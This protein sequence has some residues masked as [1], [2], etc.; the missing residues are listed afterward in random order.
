MYFKRRYRFF[1][2]LVKCSVLEKNLIR[3][4]FLLVVFNLGFG[5]AFYFLEKEAQSDLTWLD[6]LW[7]S[8]VTMTTVGYGDLYPHSDAARFLVAYPCF[9]FGIALL[10]YFL[11]ITT[12]TFIERATRKKRGLMQINLQ[13]HI[14]LCNFPGIERIQ[15]VISE[16]SAHPEYS[17]K[18][19]VLVSDQFTELPDSLKRQGL[20]FV[21][22]DPNQE[23]VLARASISTSYG[24]IVFAEDSNNQYCDSQTFVIGSTLEIIR[25]E[26][27]RP[28]KI[29]LEQV[30]LE[31][32]KMLK[33][34]GSDGVVIRGA[35]SDFLLVQ[36]FLYPGTYFVYKQL[37]SNLVGSQIYLLETR[38]INVKVYQFQRAMLES[39]YK[40][41]LLGIVENG[42]CL[43]NPEKD[44]V[45]TCQARLI[46]LAESAA[47]FQKIEK[48][49][50]KEIKKKAKN[51]FH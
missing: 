35:I 26:K 40:I 51:L 7:W 18:E 49:I 1:V 30:S 9:I 5:S 6:S 46:V 41:Q 28:F 42:Q 50:E 48:E 11:G 43:L 21:K 38:L 47:D 34:T 39:E 15:R 22:G 8:M 29:I 31:N 12:E 32:P 16:L 37:V 17:Y 44:L 2:K 23:E 13:N 27:G 19:F 3:I 10:G 45:L 14:V 25:Q 36:E 20:F 33:R 24:A 4:S